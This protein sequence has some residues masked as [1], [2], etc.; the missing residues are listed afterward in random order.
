MADVSTGELDRLYQT[1]GVTR[2]LKRRRYSPGAGGG[3][4]LEFESGPS[5]RRVTRRHFSRVNHP[6]LT[7]SVQL[8]PLVRMTD[9]QLSPGHYRE[10]VVQITIDDSADESGDSMPGLTSGL[11]LST[12]SDES[13]EDLKHTKTAENVQD[14]TDSTSSCSSTEDSG[15]DNEG[16]D[17]KDDDEDGNE[18][19]DVTIKDTN[20]SNNNLDGEFSLSV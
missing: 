16:G 11:D 8:E 9:Q 5:D 7:V 4:D 12:S 2:S 18:G 14:V 6:S 3:Q 13:F 20:G 17:G 1:S 19:G 15:D 10:P